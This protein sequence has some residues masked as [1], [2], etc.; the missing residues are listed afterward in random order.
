MP[1]CQNASIMRGSVDDRDDS[2]FATSLIARAARIVHD[3]TEVDWSR[4]PLTE[5][6][7]EVRRTWLAQQMEC[8]PF[9]RIEIAELAFGMDDMGTDLREALD[10]LFMIA[11]VRAARDQR[12][13]LRS[14]R[15]EVNRHEPRL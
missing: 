1:L 8:G 6:E 5:Y 9:G 11:E 2:A 12:R 10:G 4:D 3:A 15:D 13:S 7:A 14:A